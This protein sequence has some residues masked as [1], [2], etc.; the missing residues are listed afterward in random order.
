MSKNTHHSVM[1]TFV[2][3]SITLFVIILAAGGTAFVV[4]MQQ[5]IRANKEAKL[6]QI[7]EIERIKLETSV[8]SE[9]AIVMKMAGSPLIKEY[10]INR[11]SENPELEKTASKEIVDYRRAFSGNL[12]F[13]VKDNDKRFYSDNGDSV[14]TYIVDLENSDNYWYNMTLYETEKYNFNINYNPE[15]RLTNLWINAPVFDDNR[16]PTGMLG[17]GVD[18]SAFIDA[19]YKN[20]KDKINL[21]FFND[22]GEITGAKDSE[23]AAVKKSINEEMSKTKTDI[24]AAAKTLTPGEIRII[25]IPQGQLAIGTVQTLEWYAVAFSPFSINDYNSAITVLFL[26][27]IAGIAILFIIFNIFIARNLKTLS[28]TMEQLEVA[29]KSKSEFLATMSHEIRTPMNAIIGI[30]QIQLQKENLPEEYA[31]AF[32]KIY[33]SGNNLLG[34]INDILDMSKIESGKLKLIPSEYDLPSLINDAVQLNIVRIGEKPITFT[35]DLNENLPEKMFGD[36]LRLKQ[37]LNNLLSNAIKYTN[38]GFVKLSVSHTL[39]GGDIN[40][41][42]RIS[43]SGQGIKVKD[44]H[45]MFSEYQRFNSE[46]NRTTEGTGLGLN[47]TKKLAQMMHGKIV[48]NSVYGK[49]STFTVNVKQKAVKCDTIGPEVSQRLC[50]FNYTAKRESDKQKLTY[51]PMPYGRVLVVD[52][53]ETNLFVAQGLLSPYHLNI[54]TAGSGFAALDKI[55]RGEVY[56]VIFMDHMMPKMDGIETTKKIREFGYSGAIVALTANALAGNN[57]MFRQNGFDDFIPKPIDIRFLNASL[58]KFVRDKHPQEAQKAKAE[59]AKPAAQAAPVKNLLMNPRIIEVFC[60]DAKKA[61][62]TIRETVSGG[63]IKLFTTTVHGMKSALAH[64]GENESSAL[65]FEL[66]KAGH[67]GD[68]AYINSNME[69]FIEKLEKIVLKIS[70]DKQNDTGNADNAGDS[71]IQEETAYLKE[72]LRLIKSA[73]ENYNDAAAYASLDNLKEKRWKAQTVS[74]LEELR[75]MLFLHSDFDG[76][77]ARASKM[78]DVNS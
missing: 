78:L 64:I 10:F 13:W 38:A 5:I 21:Y 60:R 29:S 48:V 77:A 7:I 22:Y 39:N 45:K 53:V 61:A 30:T 70:P 15:M 9:I 43:D 40:L 59:A 3:F 33:H 73:C 24:A 46:A 55:Q 31:D 23:L 26:V 4:A 2:V 65:A 66:E 71:D 16:K 58:H 28:K 1:R 42:F 74:A 41:C 32:D 18:L 27:V 47:I 37:I 36:E 19:T 14:L 20:Y 44:L 6:S 63:D 67:K 69:H 62:V 68:S 76:A 75:D 51:E 54:D 49:G 17:T 56:D 52:D 57:E 25:N 34:I 11:G 50:S 12:V 8:N 35:L 72:Q